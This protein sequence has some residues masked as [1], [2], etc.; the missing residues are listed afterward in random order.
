MLTVLKTS[1]PLLLGV[2]LLMVGNGIQGSLLGIRGSIEG[3]STFEISVVMSAYFAGFLIGSQLAPA[4]IRKVGHV[5]VFAALGSLIS[6]VL[7][8]YPVAPDW[9]VWSLLRVLIGFCFSGIYITAESWLNNAATNETRGQ[10]LSA[11]MI[12]Q[13]LGIIASQAL[14]NVSDPSGFTLFVIPS[15]LVSLAFMPL[16]LAPTPAPTFATT[17]ALSFPALFRISPLGC[18]GMLLTGGVFSAMFGMA[19]VWGSM[20]GLSVRDISVFIGALYVGGLILQYPIGFLSD[21][22]DRRKLI[23]ALSAIAAVVMIVPSIFDLPFS[24]YLVVA[25][26]LGG[27]TNPVYALL[28]AYTN[29]FLGK[30][31]MAAASAGMIFLNGFGAIFGP[32]V[33]GWIMGRMG[34][35]GFFLFIAILYVALAGYALWRMTRRAAPAGTGHFAN[36]VPTASPVAASAVI[37]QG[38]SGR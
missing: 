38:Q 20:K 14:L 9:I 5:R 32:V 12:V 30:D 13:M 37:G 7:V 6:A 19:A 34:P 4:M 25:L 8:V 3:F 27:I 17:K 24:L 23:M 1:W 11:Y 33:T 10:A 29:D 21:R 16:L 22:M 2:M 26:L 36:L 28:I 18:A 31:D 15:V 35:S